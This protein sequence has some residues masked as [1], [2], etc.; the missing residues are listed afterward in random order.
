MALSQVYQNREEVQSMLV[1]A[2]ARDRK[3][4]YKEGKQEDLKEGNR[5][6]LKEKL[7]IARSLR[8]R[9]M[10]I[11]DIAEISGLSEEAVQEIIQK[12]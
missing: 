5:E 6:G 9:D 2:I 8:A 1:N 7:R 4:M 10:A 3:K 12:L 11:P